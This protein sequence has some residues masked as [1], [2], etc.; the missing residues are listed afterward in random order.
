V[1]ADHGDDAG[2]GFAVWERLPPSTSASGFSDHPQRM[3]VEYYGTAIRALLP[4]FLADLDHDRGAPLASV[5]TDARAFAAAAGADA[6]DGPRARAAKHNG[7]V[8]AFGALAARYGVLPWSEG[9]ALD[10]ALRCCCWERTRLPD[11][12][13]PPQSPGRTIAS[14]RAHIKQHLGE[15]LRVG[16]RGWLTKEELAAAPG[17][18]YP[19][20]G[21]GREFV[22]DRG[23]FEL[24]AC[25]GLSVKLAL[26]HLAGAGLLNVQEGGRR[27]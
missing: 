20:R 19:R 13:S 23:R 24:A 16:E 17:A 2:R 1:I 6:A 27:R 3:A 10:A 4:N 9:E 12:A 25:A 14:V 11:P 21:G 22:F 8:N 7:L 5:R 15:F 18:V 26:R